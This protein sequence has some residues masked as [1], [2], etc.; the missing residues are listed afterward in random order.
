MSLVLRNRRTRLR[1]V[2]AWMASLATFGIATAQAAD[3]DGDGLDDAWEKNWFGNLT[4]KASADPD[5]DGLTNGQE[6]DVGTNPTL[7]DTDG[8]G[9]KDGAELAPANPFFQ[10]DPNKFD[11]DGDFLPDGVEVNQTHTS[12]TLKDTDG[13][14]LPDNV[15]VLVSKTDPLLADTD[16]GFSSDG[17]E[18]LVDGT[19]PNDPKDDVQDTDGDGLSDWAEDNLWKTDPLIADTD[20]D[21]LT[22]GPEVLEHKTNPLDPDSDADGLSD[23]D[24]VNVW[25]TKPLVPDTDEDGLKDGDEVLVHKTDPKRKDTDWDSLSD[26]DEVN[27]HKTNPLLADS[28]GGGVLDPVEIFDGSDPN[29]AADDAGRDLDGDGLSTTYEQLVSAT[30]P[31]DPDS[32][33]DGLA[34]GQEAFPLLDHLV[35]VPTDADSDD[36]GVLD[37]AEGGVSPDGDPGNVQG[38][39]SPL[40]FDTDLDGLGDG[41][42]R[43]LAAPQKSAKSPGATAGGLFVA[44]T[45]PT[46]V[47]N[48]LMGDTDGDGLSDGAEDADH[49]GKWD[50]AQGETDPAVYDT[51]GDGMDDGWEVAYSG[52]V[53]E[54][55]PLLPLDP[56][57]AQKDNDGDGLTNLAEYKVQKHDANGQLVTN[58]TNPRATDSDKDGLQDLF[59]VKSNCGGPDPMFPGTDPNDPDTDNDG[60]ADGVEDANKNGKADAGE[61]NACKV[62][63]DGDALPDGFE[64]A[65]HDGVLDPGETDPALADTD[66]DE[67]NDSVELNFFGTNPRSVDTDGDDLPDGLEVGQVGDADPNSVTNPLSEDTDGDGVGDASEDADADGQ[68]DAGE[69]NPTMPDTDGDGLGDGLEQGKAGD[70]D[71]GSQTDPTSKDSDGDG[72]ADGMEDKDH[73]GQVDPTETDPNAAD[74]DKGGTS[75]GDEVLYDLTDPLNPLDDGMADPDGDGLLSKVEKKIGTDFTNPDTDGDTISDGDEATG[76]VAV[77]TDKDGKADAFDLDSD[78]DGLSDAEEAG[79]TA[80]QTPP[81][82]SDGDGTPDFRDLDSDDDALPDT[83]EPKWGTD[84]T[85]PDTDDD[86][87]KDG[88]D[89]AAGGIP[90]DADTDDDGVID[91]AEA[92]LADVD[93]DQLVA[94][95]DVDSDNDGIFDGTERGVTQPLADT[96]L[97]AGAFRADTDPTKATDPQLADS[98]GDGLRDGAED[99]D[100]DGALDIGESD[101]ADLASTASPTDSDGDGL[102]DAE[103]TALGSDPQDADSD[104]DGVLDLQEW[105]FSHDLDQDGLPNVLDADSDGDFLP[106]GL[107]RGVALAPTATDVARGRFT[108]DQDPSHTTHMLLRDSDGD[109]V[110]DG[111]EDDNGNG[112]VDAGEGDPLDPASQVV[113]PD[114]DGD[115]LSDAEEARCGSHPDDADSDDDGLPDGAEPNPCWDEDNDGLPGALDGDADN[116]GLGDATEVGLAAAGTDTDLSRKA[117]FPDDDPSTTTFVL[118][119]D[120]DGDG[121][122][123]GAED[124]D[125]DGIFET[126][127]RD[128][129][130][131]ADAGVTLKDQDQDGCPDLEESKL[132]TSPQD[133][134]SDDDGLRDGDEPNLG[135]DD[136]GDGLRTG[137]DSDSDGD[138]LCDGTEAGVVTPPQGTSKSGPFVADQDPTTTTWL[139]VA[140]TDHGGVSDGDEDSNHDGAMAADETDPLNPA[141]DFNKPM[142]G[143]DGGPD[144]DTADTAG[145]LVDGRIQGSLVTG[146]SAATG[147][148]ADAARPGLWLLLPLLALLAARRRRQG[149]PWLVWALVLLPLLPATE[150]RAEDGFQTLRFRPSL[151]GQGILT[152]DGATQTPDTLPTASLFLD[153]ARRPLVVTGP[154][155]EVLRELVGD[156]VTATAQASLR[157]ARGVTLGLA[158]PYAVWQQGETLS[159]APSATGSA[160]AGRAAGDLSLL[161]KFVAFDERSSPWGLAFNLGVSAPTGDTAAFTGR[162]GIAADASIVMTGR[163]RALRVGASAGVRAQGQALVQGIEDGP[164]LTAAAGLSWVPGNRAWLDVGVNLETP[165]QGPF[166]DAALDRAEAG[167]T[168][169][170]RLAD[171]VVATVG[172]MVGVREGFGVPAVRGIAG[173]A[174]APPPPNLQE[175]LDEA[176]RRRLQAEKE[177]RERAERLDTDHD[178]LPDVRDPCP[179]NAEDVDGFQDED[180][181]PD[182]DNDRDGADDGQD[183]CPNVPED[184]DG[185]E[186][187][188]GCPDQDNDGDARDD[189]RDVC[190]NTAEDFDDYEDADGCP[191]WDNDGDTVADPDDLCPDEPEAFNGVQDEDGCPERSLAVLAPNQ[192]AIQIT[193]RILFAY[194]SYRIRPESWPVVDAVAKVLREHNDLKKLRVAGHTDHIGTEAKNLRLSRQRAD[195]VRK[196]LIRRGI[197]HARLETKGYG[198]TRPLIPRSRG[199]ETVRNRRVEFVVQERDKAKP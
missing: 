189:A 133:E 3:V 27:Q 98:D 28:D 162:E 146:C 130:N 129:R 141:D 157:V 127:E 149:H 138:G 125:H 70:A 190:P 185:F 165:L 69:T 115:D 160:L 180:G 12:P 171:R 67:L 41:L 186:D 88:A 1:W 96:N 199:A 187:A 158:F 29:L 102:P 78:G 97:S 179:L 46:S 72:L 9:L 68:F 75:D 40:R 55:P 53:G 156:R 22:D 182:D 82:D 112:R 64:D 100:H 47:T 103:E 183:A 193:D 8:D 172:A 61:A 42:E 164:A 192:E 21:G 194:K 19:N 2:L 43:G 62:D 39:T 38:G 59:E 15:E 121:T 198:A 86:G 48:G 26:G 113:G 35:T 37:G 163:R 52:P 104:D 54:G 119:R 13:D 105:N 50:K 85:D 95:R 90:T 167:A 151:D 56:T 143:E 132:G 76:G 197:P 196:A 74:T 14:G 34:D 16:G 195:A 63:T 116:D 36:D 57:D 123:D 161:A 145:P 120:S 93:G 175:E 117:F 131:P 159:A 137:R 33:G 184:A 178:G 11:T 20:G 80:W 136:D 170:V 155:G 110:R 44:D 65:D 106:D 142:P 124:V 148:P 111:R 94:I 169:S 5:V 134:D 32:D 4:A 118:A 17:A 25:Q 91:S 181:C 89:I 128:P 101:A 153:Y 114:T 174:W 45:D 83:D 7:E 188:D 30:E 92:G 58:R 77:D 107:E 168:A 126:G 135:L 73:D 176:E 49:D 150:A 109:G 79:D 122:R 144:A 51:D 10:S 140:D 147:G 18:V 24:E 23:G 87:L 84:P 177:A 99:F 154:D 152:M 173:L 108:P 6:Q 139:L 31:M 71:P 191:D 60:T 66:G 166:A 81:V